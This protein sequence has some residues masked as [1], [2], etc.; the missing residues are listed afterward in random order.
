MRKIEEKIVI[1][2]GKLVYAVALKT[3]NKD[4][5]DTYLLIRDGKIHFES[6]W[7][8]SVVAYEGSDESHSVAK[9]IFTMQLQCAIKSM[10]GE[11][12]LLESVLTSIGIT[13]VLGSSLTEA[14]KL[15]ITQQV[16]KE[17]V[18]SVKPKA[19]KKISEEKQERKPKAKEQPIKIEE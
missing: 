16:K 9:E 17:I 19:I 15:L 11:L 14:Q 7:F 3:E 2:N 4:S 12:K 5:R 8:S 18:D 6:N 13:E 1:N 10:V